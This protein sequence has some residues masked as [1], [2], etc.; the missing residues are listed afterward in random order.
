MRLPEQCAV[1]CLLTLE[2]ESAGNGCR[3]SDPDFAVR[4]ASVRSL[5]AVFGVLFG[6]KLAALHVAC[7]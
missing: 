2:L 3:K 1:E 7:I 4:H 5:Y 6:C